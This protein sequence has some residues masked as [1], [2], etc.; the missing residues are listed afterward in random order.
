[1]SPRVPERRT[2]EEIIARYTLEPG[3]RDIYVEGPSDLSLIDW[4]LRASG[5]SN[6]AVYEVETVEIPPARIFENGL[7]DGNRGRVITLAVTLAEALSGIDLGLTCIADR[8]TAFL[9]EEER[10]S[11]FLLYT[12]YAN[13]EMY[14]FTQNAIDKFLSLVVRKRPENPDHILESF[15]P[16]LE[17]LFL[18]RVANRILGLGLSEQEFEGCCSLRS[19]RA[20]FDVDE[21]IKRYLAKN[22]AMGEKCR[23]YDTIERFRPRLGED[24]RMQ[25]DGH[26]FVGLLTW[27]IRSHGVIASYQKR[28]AV[29]RSLYGC[30]EARV[31]A[32][33]P[34]FR[35]LLERIPA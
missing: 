10:D 32:D 35:T 28:A 25:M 6:F 33:E 11:K 5:R 7:E 8:D 30:L 31:L 17:E 21:Y 19:G 34:L 2:L 16:I 18:I 15:R 1:M 13:M 4:F 29:G 3:L 26:D 9:L 24:P 12:D 22:S 20:T 14:F 23:V 27:Y